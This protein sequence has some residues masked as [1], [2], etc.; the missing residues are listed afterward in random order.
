MREKQL[1]ADLQS[2]KDR[3]ERCEF[4]GLHK[5]KEEKLLHR[6]TELHLKTQEDALHRE[7]EQQKLQNAQREHGET[8]ALE[9]QRT[10]HLRELQRIKEET[11]QS[12]YEIKL[13]YTQEKNA[14]EERNNKLLSLMHATEP[15]T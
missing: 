12:L 2:Y 9:Q 5:L 4:E 15:P 11:E 14:L 10:E 1:E 7:K 8:K 13:I 3:L 6:E